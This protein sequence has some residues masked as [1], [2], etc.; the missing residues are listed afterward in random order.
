MLGAARKPV[1]GGEK[2]S[3]DPIGRRAWGCAFTTRSYG[4]ERKKPNPAKKITPATVAAITGR[5]TEEAF[6]RT[7]ITTLVAPANAKSRY[8]NGKPMFHPR[9]SCHAATIQ[10]AATQASF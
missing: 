5:P 4:R 6:P 10:P 7:N 2:Y 8:A 1:K 9:E 3:T